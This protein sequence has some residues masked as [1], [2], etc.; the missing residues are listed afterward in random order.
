MSWYISCDIQFYIIGVL[1]IYLYTKNVKCGICLLSL[2]LGASIF[3][4]FIITYL[5]KI[6]GMLKVHLP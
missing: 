5:T 3:V 4:P 2:M 6:D 1:F